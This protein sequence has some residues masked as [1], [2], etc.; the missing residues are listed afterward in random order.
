[1]TT[2]SPTPPTD[3]QLH[4]HAEQF[5]HALLDSASVQQIGV[6]RWWERAKTALETAAAS[7]TSWRQCVARAGQKLQV[8]TFTA[9]ASATVATLAEV[10]DDETA[11]ARWRTLATRDALTIT[12]MVRHQRTL[13]RTATTTT[14]DSTSEDPR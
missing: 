5:L 6:A 9:S 8:N 14:T 2:A 10:L 3:L 7:S 13:Q 1:M 11:F 4:A 12:A